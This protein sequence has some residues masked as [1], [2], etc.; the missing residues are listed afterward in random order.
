MKCLA[1][2]T[3]IHLF[4]SRLPLFVPY[5]ITINVYR[6][7]STPNIQSSFRGQKKRVSSHHRPSALV[8]IHKN[9]AVFVFYIISG[10][11]D[12]QFRPKKWLPY[13]THTRHYIKYLYANKHVLFVPHFFLIVVYGAHVDP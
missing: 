2:S 7:L 9:Y 8:K 5:S 6:P 12:F 11:M 10:E 1:M 4:A 13:H 3:C